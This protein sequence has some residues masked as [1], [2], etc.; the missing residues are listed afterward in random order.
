M[1]NKKKNRVILDDEKQLMS[2]VTQQI[3][4]QPIY[5][6]GDKIMA[7]IAKKTQLIK[8]IHT[9]KEKVQ[10]DIFIGKQLER[11]LKKIYGF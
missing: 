4:N 1:K 6:V 9:E 11:L 7:K 5:Q 10:R 3:Y 2:F 8:S